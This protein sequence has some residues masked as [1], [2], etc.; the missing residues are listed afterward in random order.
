[1]KKAIIAAS[2]GT[3]YAHGLEKSISAVE[4]LL[5]R[6]FY[7]YE[8]R[9]A[10]T[11]SMVIAALKK[12]GERIDSVGEALEKLAV[13]G[14]SEVIIQPTHIISGFEYDK[15]LDAA[16]EYKDRFKSLKV[17]APLLDSDD[18][19]ERICD[20]FEME[21]GS[22]NA[23]ALMGHGTE[24]SANSLYSRFAE[25]CRQKGYKNIF[26]GT[27]EG[28]PVIDDIIPQ[29]KAGGYKK[30]IVTPLMFVAGDHANNDMAGDEPESWK[31]RLEKAGFEV[32]S[33]V[34]GLGEYPEIQSMY[35][36]HI[37]NI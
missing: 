24:H 8:V 10:F 23:T 11:S 36:Q 30:V 34:K 22:E 21:F 37:K 18:D 13:Q 1:M 29:I 4:E 33:V 31:S 14:F 6:E 12:R 27:V 32:V 20:F 26:V 7:G 35:A 9:R 16:K 25:K 3:T 28:T 15:I 19:I 5:R 17:G 2:F